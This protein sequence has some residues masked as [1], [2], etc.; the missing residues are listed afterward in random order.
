MGVF[1]YITVLVSV[2]LG[3]GITHL[4]IGTSKL[5]QHREQ[6]RL[7]VPHS[8]W[9]VNVL[10]YILMIW[11]GMYYWNQHE[12]WFAYEY[13]FITLYAI[14]LFFLASMLY[15]WDMEKDIDLD[16]YFYRNRRWFFGTL[17]IGWL[18]DIP[19]TVLKAGTG[20]R[21]LPQDYAVFVTVELAMAA[22]GF[23]TSNRMVHLLLPFVWFTFTVFFAF[24]SIIGRIDT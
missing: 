20:L 5:I 22:V 8:M 23:L 11:W 24:A 13:L 16:A 2:I 21:E 17:F 9:A 10:L 19:E 4:A 15:P 18:I 12:D 6:V 3:L 1:E 7:Y 14:V